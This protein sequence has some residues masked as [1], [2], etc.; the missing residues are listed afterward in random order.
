MG[1]DHEPT[2]EIDGIH[3]GDFVV[4]P[5]PA[6]GTDGHLDTP[7]SRERDRQKDERPAASAAVVPLGEGGE[8]DASI[9]EA[10]ARLQGD[11]LPIPIILRDPLT[12]KPIG[13]V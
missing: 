1:D 13:S 10:R 2:L 4:R 8:V 6:F 12:G 11:G 5:V 9:E 7:A 3:A